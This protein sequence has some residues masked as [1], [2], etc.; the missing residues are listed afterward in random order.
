M[1]NK[2]SIALTLV[3]LLMLAS[4]LAQ[5]YSYGYAGSTLR[6]GDSGAGCANCHGANPAVVEV[7]LEG[8]PGVLPGKTVRYSVI[9]DN[10]TNASAKA[11]F[12]TAV[13]RIPGNQPVFSNVPG[14][15]T[16]TTDSATQIVNNNASYPLKLP[17]D[18]TAVYFIDLSV[19]VS[20]ETGSSFT[21]YTVGEAGWS[22]RH[23]GWRHAPNFTVRVGP[24]APASLHADQDSA[25][26]SQINL[27]W[28]DWN[29]GEHFRMLVKAGSPPESP[30]DEAATLVYEGPDTGATATGLSPGTV[31]HFAVWGKDPDDEIYSLDAT[32]ASAATLPES[33]TGLVINPA[34]GDGIELSWSGD[35]DEYRLLRRTDEYPEAPTDEAATV[36]YEGSASNATDSDLNV[37]TGYYYRVWG[38]VADQ[39]IFSEAS[40]EANWIDR[41]FTDRYQMP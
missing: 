41:I 40:S 30:T 1:F 22:T 3:A 21:L 15:P 19:P 36:I 33:P 9:I 2:P 8:P 11:G 34:S 39:N 5:A 16:A 28:T 4:G 10:I 23:V 31:Y 26:T 18:G 14:E 35:S 25:T 38:K 12:T 13:D 37:D 29:Q 7:G 20:A 6:P 27:A 32:E 17:T 24:P